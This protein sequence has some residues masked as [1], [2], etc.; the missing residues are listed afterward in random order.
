MGPFFWQLDH[1]LST[2]RKKCIFPFE[3]PKT[4]R[5]NSKNWCWKCKMSCKLQQMLVI[6]HKMTAGPR[7]MTAGPCKMTAAPHKMT[8]ATHLMFAK[9]QRAPGDPPYP[10]TFFRALGTKKKIES[11]PH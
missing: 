1:F 6:L 3:N 11:D 5:K 10:Y 9:D 8:A 7:K 2:F 4:L